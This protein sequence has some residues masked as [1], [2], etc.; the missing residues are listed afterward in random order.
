MFTLWRVENVEL[1]EIEILGIERPHYFQSKIGG[2]GKFSSET[3]KIALKG[4][5]RRMAIG[6]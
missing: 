4:F 5:L 6:D 1:S 2:C 3:L